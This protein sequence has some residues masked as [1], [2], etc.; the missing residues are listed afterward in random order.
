MRVQRLLV[1]VSLVLVGASGCGG[2]DSE[3]GSTASDEDSA[4]TVVAT[5]DAPAQ[6]ASP[7][8]ITTGDVEPVEPIESD[9]DPP[10]P[11]PS[12]LPEATAPVG[13]SAPQLPDDAEGIVALFDALPDELLGGTRDLV[14]LG[15]GNIGASYDA[16]DRQCT[17]VGLQ[18]IDLTANPGAYPEDW[19]AEHLVAL[20]ASGVDWDVEDA[21]HEG[22]L[23]WVTFETTCGG[24]EIE[25]DEI[26][27]GATWGNEGSPWVFFVGAPD[28]AGR[29]TLLTEFVDAAFAATETAE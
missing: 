24:E 16:G 21:G 17:E 25:R 13:L 2:D 8:T 19:R 27:S 26:I 28:D 18:A 6:A 9:D 3:S 14:N 12:T 29:D 10:A 20:F 11:N 22:T 15:P 4:T 23:Y 7:T 5:T 1:T